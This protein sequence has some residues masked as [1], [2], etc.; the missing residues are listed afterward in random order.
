MHRILAASAIVLPLAVCGATAASADAE[1]AVPV[2]HFD[3]GAFTVGPDG[4][5]LH[6]IEVKYGPD[7]ASYFEGTLVISE[8]GVS[9][10]FV[11]T[12]IGHAEG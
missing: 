2:A 6:V 1:G 10:S 5:A 11:D 8:D 7:G 12:G 4:S 9:G 3:K